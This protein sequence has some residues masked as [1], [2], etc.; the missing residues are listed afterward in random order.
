VTPLVPVRVTGRVPLDPRGRRGWWPFRR[1][2]W[3][4]TA[5]PA[6]PLTIH[7]DGGWLISP[8]KHFETDGGS[9]PRPLWIIYDP[10]T[11]AAAFV[12]HDSGYEGRTL[13]FAHEFAP[14]RWEERAVTR[15]EMD[16]LLRRVVRLTGGT[17]VDSRVI[18]R[19]VRL[20][21]WWA[22]SMRARASAEKARKRLRDG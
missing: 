14:E 4:Y 18:Y 12:V 1:T 7:C 11:W 19:A 8:D 22:W 6:D 3:E 16:G 13:W 20:F 2:I 21:G 17:L 5:D 9:I 10:W 15:A